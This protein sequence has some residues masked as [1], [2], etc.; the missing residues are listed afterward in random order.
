MG[1]ATLALCI[2][3]EDGGPVLGTDPILDDTEERATRC[4]PLPVGRYEP[5]L[6]FDGFGLL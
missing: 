5:T 3:K 6:G 1:R 4:T 2:D